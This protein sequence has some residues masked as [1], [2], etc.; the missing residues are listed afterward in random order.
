MGGAAL[1][2]FNNILYIVYPGQGGKN[3]WYAYIDTLDVHA[4]NIQIKT[5]R[6]TPET[7][8]P[9]GLAAFNGHLCLAYKGESLTGHNF[10]FSYGS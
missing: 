9:V 2:V 8:A 7:S 1:A 10:W 5:S 6:S 4:G 3:L